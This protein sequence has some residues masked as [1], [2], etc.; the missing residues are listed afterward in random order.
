M[1]VCVDFV[2]TLFRLERIKYD[3]IGAQLVTRR[4]KAQCWDAMSEKLQ[5]VRGL[6]ATAGP[7]DGVTTFP[8]VSH[9]KEELALHRRLQ[10]LCK[11]GLVEQEWSRKT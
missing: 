10:F 9:T 2:L 4:I 8:I 7:T 5:I 6:K 1:C 3:N 11:M